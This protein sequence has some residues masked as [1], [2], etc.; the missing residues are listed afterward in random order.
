MK[1]YV[2]SVAGVF[3]DPAG[4]LSYLKIIAVALVLLPGAA[5]A[6]GWATDDLG[7]RPVTEAIHQTGLW[8]IRFLIITLAVTPARGVL[9][10]PR[11]IM[12]RRLLGV[13]A[14]CYASAHFLLFI[15][16]HHWNLYTVLVEILSRFYL[17]IGYIALLGL[18]AL[19]LTS[20]DDWQRSL[21]TSW[22]KLHKLIF[23]IAGLALFHYAVQ[24]KAD[25]SDAVFLTGLFVWLM[26]WRAV[27]RRWQTKLWPLPAFAVGAG[28]LAA[29]M[30]AGWYVVRNNVD[31][32]MVLGANLDLS[33]GPRPAVAA[34]LV[35]CAVIVVAA[36]RKLTKRRRMPGG[37]VRQA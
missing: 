14:A 35:G 5:V 16:D 1:D 3:R 22:K 34:A 12:L 18:L 15:V 8:A 9:D 17:T 20:T 32:W 11:V 4:R 30:E 24:S 28:L 25:I 37:A 33:F 27:P 23:P 26:F 21:G 6:L 2:T 10:L 7:A 36:A 29:L 13:T 31:G 19:A